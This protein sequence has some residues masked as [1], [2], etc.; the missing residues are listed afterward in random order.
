MGCCRAMGRADR[1]T[2]CCQRRLGADAHLTYFCMKQKLRSSAHRFH[3]KK[4]ARRGG[5]APDRYEVFALSAA[6]QVD[7]MLDSAP[8]SSPASLSWRALPMRSCWQKKCC[9]MGFKRPS[10][11]QAQGALEII[12][13]HEE[14]DA[15]MAAIRGWLVPCFAG[16]ARAN[17]CCWPTKRRWW[18]GVMCSAGCARA[19]PPPAHRQ[20][21]FSHFFSP[22][23]KILRV[24][25][26]GWIK[27]FAHGAWRAV[28]YPCAET[29]HSH[30]PDQA[31]AHPS[32]S[33]GTKTLGGCRTLFG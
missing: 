11:W 31:C 1:V 14:V 19:A 10:W 13:S 29:W 23:L 33:M 7:L 6:T 25:P 30:H 5:E 16:P 18:W 3:R 24:G 21:A 27:H 22:R 8:N 28:P 15:V 26:S 4:H 32:F 12:A 20:R 9:K 2:R 17:A